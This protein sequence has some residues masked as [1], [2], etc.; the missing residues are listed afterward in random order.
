MKSVHWE[1]R[2]NILGSNIRGWE[3]AGSLHCQQGEVTNYLY[4]LVFL[5]RM[6]VVTLPL[7]QVCT[8]SSSATGTSSSGAT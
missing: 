2:C 1:P 7:S 8:F 4:L 5:L 3:T 6:K